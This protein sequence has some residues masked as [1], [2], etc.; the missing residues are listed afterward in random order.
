M[1]RPQASAGGSAGTAKLRLPGFRLLAVSEA[2]GELEQ[3]VE[4]T[5]TVA[6]CS[7]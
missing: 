5:A 2:F 4:T 1:R 7:G 6:W 3:A